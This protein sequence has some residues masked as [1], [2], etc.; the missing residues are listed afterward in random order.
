MAVNWNDPEF[1][2]SRARY[3]DNDPPSYGTVVAALDKVIKERDALRKCP[4]PIASKE[5]LEF[6]LTMLGTAYA[7]HCDCGKVHR[8]APEKVVIQYRRPPCST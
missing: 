4:L 8:L 6:D 1:V 7:Y 3:S 2:L 5:E